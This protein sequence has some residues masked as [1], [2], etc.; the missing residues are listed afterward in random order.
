MHPDKLSQSHVQFALRY[1]G[2]QQSATI[3]AGLSC[4]ASG[5]CEGLETPLRHRTEA[6]SKAVSGCIAHLPV[7]CSL[8]S[9]AYV[10]LPVPSL[11]CVQCRVREPSSEVQK[12]LLDFQDW[13]LEHGLPKQQ[14]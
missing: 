6:T 13:T 4:T 11:M 1:P 3:T 10:L 12:E 7:T 14:V 5:L 2:G 8:S 9:A